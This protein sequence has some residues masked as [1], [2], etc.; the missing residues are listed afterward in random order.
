MTRWAVVYRRARVVDVW[1]VITEVPEGVGRP[2]VVDALEQWRNFP[3]WQARMV[4]GGKID[5][6]HERRW[7]STIAEQI[8]DD[9]GVAG[10]EIPQLPWDR[11]KPEQRTITV[12]VR[13][14]IHAG[15][16]RA[17]ADKGVSLA[18][19]VRETLAQAAS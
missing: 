14:E 16:R 19:L 17:A 12:T 18:Q 15:L 3:A 1:A 5:V 7:S 9:A 10:D 11:L 6:S 8:R 2:E 13:P 4:M